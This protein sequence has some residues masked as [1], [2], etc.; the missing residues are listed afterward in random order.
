[1]AFFNQPLTLRIRAKV[2]KSVEPERAILVV[3]YSLLDD[4]EV[5]WKPAVLRVLRAGRVPLVDPDQD[6]LWT[7]TDLG[8]DG[9]GQLLKLTLHAEALP[10]RLKES[11]RPEDRNLF[12]AIVGQATVE[13]EL[14]LGEVANAE[15]PKPSP[16]RASLSVRLDTVFYE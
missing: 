16:L 5:V 1:M 14:C 13:L 12:E 6:P 4:E 9:A 8:K 10:K 3:R 11:K 15:Y 7:V 2:G